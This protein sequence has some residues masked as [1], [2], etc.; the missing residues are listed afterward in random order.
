MVSFHINWLG[1]YPKIFRLLKQTLM[2]YLFSNFCRQGYEK[3]PNCGYLPKSGQG[4][5]LR[6]LIFRYTER[7]RNM[8]VQCK[9]KNKYYLHMKIVISVIILS[10]FL[11]T[12][13][14]GQVTS[15]KIV[16]KKNEALSDSI[17]QKPYPYILPAWGAKV[18]AKGFDLPYSAGLSLNYA[19]QQSDL[20]IDNLSVGFNN[21]PMYNIDEIIRFNSAVSTTSLL[22][23]RPDFWV[24]PFLNVYGLFMKGNSSTAIDAGVWLPDSANVWREVTAFS[25]KAEFAV[26]GM[27]FGMTPTVGVA[28]AFMAFDLNVAWTDVN[29]LDKPVFSFVFGP[30]FGKSIKFKKPERTLAFWAGGFR[31]HI[32]SETNGSLPLSDVLPIDDLQAKVDDGLEK[33]ED[34]RIMVDEWWNDLSEEE[35]NNPVNKARYETAN[36]VLETAGNTL[37]TIDGALNDDQTATVQYSLTKQP[38]D[39]WNFVVGSQFQINKHFMVRAEYG[40]LGSRQQLTTGL[41][42]RFGL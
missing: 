42:Y 12:R 35:Q 27:G 23:F 17:K 7:S 33:V 40:F 14:T 10:L 32:S 29:A 31:V 3:I 36:R 20:V 13:T 30:R 1:L 38:K 39:M 37:N 34:T 41:Q 5:P 24:L 8:L 18:A 9:H 25:S 15:N 21:G 16:G 2:A 28:G 19:W 26:T 4:V 11:F 6:N 22:N